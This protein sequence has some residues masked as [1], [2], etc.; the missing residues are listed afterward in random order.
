MS[1]KGGS[2]EIR[3]EPTAITQERDNDGLDQGSRNTE[4]KKRSI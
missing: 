4:Y 2:T 3:Q 1:S